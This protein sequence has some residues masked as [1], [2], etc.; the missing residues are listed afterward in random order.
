VS[1]AGSQLF[2]TPN[3]LVSSG[4]G[5]S[6]GSGYFGSHRAD[7]LPVDFVHPSRSLYLT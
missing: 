7:G 5:V 4:Y 2:E 1:Y 6:L 3:E